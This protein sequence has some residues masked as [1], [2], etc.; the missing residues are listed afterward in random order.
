MA[1]DRGKRRLMFRINVA[2]TDCDA[3]ACYDCVIPLVLALAQ[4]QAGL[5]VKTAQFFLRA[6][7]QLKYHM[8][9]G[10][11]PTDKG[12]T[13]TNETPIYIIG[14]GATD[15]LPNWTLVANA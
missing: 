7:K 9:T 6:L 5:P 15:A 11:G 2:F 12:I 8:V 10:Y 1:A 13:P 14:Q 3:K 4:I